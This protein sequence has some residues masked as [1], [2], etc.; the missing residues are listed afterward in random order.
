MAKAGMDVTE[1]TTPC[2]LLDI[3][4]VKENANS[5]IERCRKLGVKLRPHMK[6]HKCL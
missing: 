5:M 2:L 4:K 3:D 1:V 6:T